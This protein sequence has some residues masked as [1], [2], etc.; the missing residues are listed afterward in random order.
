MTSVEGFPRRRFGC[1]SPRGPP[2]LA[3]PDTRKTGLPPGLPY[4]GAVSAEQQALR[5]VYRAAGRI[6]GAGSGVCAPSWLRLRVIAS[7]KRGA[8]DGIQHCRAQ[9]RRAAGGRRESRGDRGRPGPRRA[10]DGERLR[11]RWSLAS[12]ANREQRAFPGTAAAAARA[13][14]GRSRYLDARDRL[15]R[16]GLLVSRVGRGRGQSTRSGSCSRSPVR[17]GTARSMRDC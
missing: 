8:G 12:F 9:P 7:T 4:I 13:G 3:G 16:R 6:R 5:A 17:G 1:G 14:L 11:S 15:V 2:A 10:D